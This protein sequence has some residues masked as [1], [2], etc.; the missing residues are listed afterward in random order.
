MP[1]TPDVSVVIPVYNEEAV[2]PSLFS[3]LSPVL[4]GLGRPYE[5]V[6][7]DDGSD[8][9]S[10]S[11]LDALRESHRESTR[12]VVLQG[13]FGQH[14]A[15][16]AGFAEARGRSVV[17]L[18]ADL[19]N[20]PEEIPRLLAALAG[21]ADYVGTIREHRQDPA[22]R[23]WASHVMNRVRERASG[24]PIKDHGSMLRAYDRTLVD[25]I[26]RCPESSAYVP[27]LAYS[28]ARA[29][30]EIAVAHAPRAAGASKYSL[31]DLIRLH[32]DLTTGYS[33]MPFHAFSILGLTM[34]AVSLVLLFV[35]SLRSAGAP[36][37][38]LCLVCLLLASGLV[39]IGL[40]GEYAV[41]IYREVRRRPRYVVRTVLGA[42]EQVS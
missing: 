28:F 36:A 19:Q 8:D 16:L 31:S 1:W 5:I 42:D 27:V 10:L 14:M 12:V 2:L 17:T 13:N 37:V 21:G 3:R 22:W 30:A 29:P 11:I 26:N 6:F 15:V 33:T 39:G 41:R 34:S 9:R 20:P 25:L 4:E 18:D 24:I 7:V 38:L 40:L 32:F 23:R 35:F